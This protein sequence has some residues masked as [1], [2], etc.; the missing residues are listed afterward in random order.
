MRLNDKTMEKTDETKLENKINQFE[1]ILIEMHYAF[2]CHRI[3]HDYT[4]TR[5]YVN[6]ITL[7]TFKKISEVSAINFQ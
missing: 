5:P 2:I 1:N 3:V 7:I 4:H 6:K